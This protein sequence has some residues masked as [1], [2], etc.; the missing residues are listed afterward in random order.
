[1]HEQNLFGLFDI[2][3]DNAIKSDELFI[4]N[5]QNFEWVKKNSKRIDINSKPIFD[6]FFNVNNIPINEIPQYYTSC[7]WGQATSNY[8]LRYMLIEHQDN[9]FLVM[10]R[11]VGIMFHSQ[12]FSISYKVLCNNANISGNKVVIPFFKNFERVKTYEV[13]CTENDNWDN[14]NFYVTKSYKRKKRQRKHYRHANEL[15]SNGVK[16]VI[17]DKTNIKAVSYEANNLY[18]YF[19]ENRFKFNTKTA[20]RMLDLCINKDCG[21]AFAFYY[22]DKLIGIEILSK[23][24]KNAYFLHCGK[25]ITSFSLEKIVAYTQCDIVIAKKIKDYLGC[26]SS[27]YIK[28]Y[29]FEHYLCD[30]IFVDGVHGD[31]SQLIHKQSWYDNAIYYKINQIKDYGNNKN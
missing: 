20:N 9:I 30:A 14:C 8:K 4:K 22:N 11:I 1:M 13:I 18:K 12:Y 17:V 23:D 26:L 7:Y 28:D 19:I 5:N 2:I 29:L 6:F 15:L 16:I 25:N 27:E 31:K 24:Y 10:L 21:I 3:K